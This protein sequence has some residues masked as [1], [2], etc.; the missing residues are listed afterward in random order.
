MQKKMKRTLF[1]V[2]VISLSLGFASCGEELSEYKNPEPEKVIDDDGVPS[3]TPGNESMFGIYSMFGTNSDTWKS[4]K[5][6][7][8]TNVNLHNGGASSWNSNLRLEAIW[9]VDEKTIYW[10]EEY[11]GFFQ[12]RP[13]TD[14]TSILLESEPYTV[15]YSKVVVNHWQQYTDTYYLVHYVYKWRNTDKW[16]GRYAMNGSKMIIHTDETTKWENGKEY[17]A[18]DYNTLTWDYSDGTIDV[19]GKKYRKIN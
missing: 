10:V 19:D 6:D 17:V 15:T 16:E 4:L 8:E 5:T 7:A 9:I 11:M 14:D 3:G 18:V 12:S 13:T 2:M 1:S